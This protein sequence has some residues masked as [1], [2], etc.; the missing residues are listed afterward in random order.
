[1]C[2]EQGALHMTMHIG[3]FHTFG[4]TLLPTHNQALLVV[5]LQ[6]EIAQPPL[7]SQRDQR[8]TR[9]LVGGVMIARNPLGPSQLVWSFLVYCK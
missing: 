2:S 3:R 8:K 5:P 4:H 9:P 6:E 1:M 7:A